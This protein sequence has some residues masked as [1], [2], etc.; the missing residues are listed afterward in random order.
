M[1]LSVVTLRYFIFVL[2]I[3]AV[4]NFVIAQDIPPATPLEQL[5][6]AIEVAK[7]HSDQR[8]AFTVEFWSSDGKE[9]FSLIVRYDPRLPEGGRWRAVELSEDDLTKKVRK[10]LKQLEKI[11]RPDEQ[12]LY[13]DLD[14]A[15]GGVT[16]AEETETAFIFT[17]PLII[18]DLPEDALTARI[19]FE[20]DG[21]FISRIEAQS[22][23][24]FKPASV[25]KVKEM[26]MTQ[27][28]ARSDDG[29]ALLVN[30]ESDVSGSAL[31][32]S[33]DTQNRQIFSDIV[34]V[35]VIEPDSEAGE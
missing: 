6:G 33:F 26:R 1:M 32:K 30:S 16:F 5:H 2:I 35:E 17:G 22:V 4:P 12:F 23:K 25:A 27:L 9:E 24:P 28:Y 13:D 21:M 14:E 11:D 34:P 3:S 8:Y 19:V 20:K 31:F 15:I 7:T 10:R 29:P 18:D